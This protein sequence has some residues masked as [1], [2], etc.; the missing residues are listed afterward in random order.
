MA[1]IGAACGRHSTQWKGEA[2]TN[3]EQVLKVAMADE[4]HLTRLKKGARVW[5][6]WRKE[7][8]DAHIFLYRAKLSK[9]NLSGDDLGEAY[10]KQANLSLADLT[11]AD[12][13]GANLSGADLTLADLRGADLTFADLSRANLSG[14]DLS[15]GN[16]SGANLSRANLMKADL[17]EADLTGASLVEAEINE[18]KISG[19]LVYAVNVWNLRGEFE[20]QKDL[21]ITPRE[22]PVITVDNIN[23]AQFIYLILNNKEIRD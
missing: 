7:H 19:S 11:F 14:D 17:I 18:A 12:L 5:N 3:E 20:E 22:E 8:P 16:L 13:R 23:V 4:K 9:A 10:L 1:F 6:K 2:M 21:I 15:D